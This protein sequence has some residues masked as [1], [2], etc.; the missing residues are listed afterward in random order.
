M[1][2]PATSTRDREPPGHSPAVTVAAPAKVNLQLSVGPLHS[3][4]FH[5]LATVF[6]AVALYDEV[7]VSPAR[8][9]AGVSLTVTGQSCQD[10]PV[11]P[12]N[13]AW[14]AA[15]LLA[16]TAGVSAD[17]HIAVRK[18][19]PVAGGMAGGSADAA[20][21]LLACARLWGL[22]STRSDLTPLAA[23]LGSDVPFILMGGTA[24]GTG[25]G[26]RLTAALVSGAYHWVFALA[27]VGLS[28][29]SVYGQ[30]DALATAAA[31]PPRVSGDLMSALRRGDATAVGRNLSND[32]QSAAI[33]LRPGLRSLLELGE[34]AGA[35]GSL[36][37]GSGPTV[38]M[39]VAD[40]DAAMSLTVLLSSSGLCSA[41]RYAM[42]PV[43]GAHVVRR[44][45]G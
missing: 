22:P 44:E 13:L 7:T 33:S 19:I 3:D 23:Q 26:D 42:G 43:A 27:H 25:R 36:V 34:D 39:L 29:P 1:V 2:G 31:G 11:G 38:A 6:Q 8:P 4:G 30:F 5:P 10:V 9:G 40:K 18:G 21:S 45:R 14:R 41:V 20:A 28:T 12:E 15:V 17:V 32:L 37:S 24:V 35:L 16:D